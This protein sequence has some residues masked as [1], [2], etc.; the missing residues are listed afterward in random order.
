MAI[1]QLESRPPPVSISPSQ[2]PQ[3]MPWTPCSCLS[4]RK[5]DGMWPWAKK[6]I[7]NGGVSSKTD[8]IV[9]MPPKKQMDQM[10]Y[11][12]IIIQYYLWRFLMIMG[13]FAKKLA[14]SSGFA[15]WLPPSKR[16]QKL[17]E[18]QSFPFYSRF[19]IPFG[20]CTGAYIFKNLP[21]A[22]PLCKFQHVR[23]ICRKWFQN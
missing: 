14:I 8:G 11:D 3:N 2:W 9:I 5:M 1:N 23:V 16:L 13:W 4:Q 10:V 22:N 12:S 6:T 7:R 15:G 21:F 17:M 19:S 20:W 18:I